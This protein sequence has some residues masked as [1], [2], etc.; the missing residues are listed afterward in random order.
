M[1]KWGRLDWEEV[2]CEGLERKEMGEGGWIG[3]R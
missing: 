3:K 2:S 1:G